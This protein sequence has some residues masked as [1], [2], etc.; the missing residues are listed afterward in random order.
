MRGTERTGEGI[1][2]WRLAAA[3]AL[4]A[5][6]AAPALAWGQL[7]LPVVDPTTPAARDTE[8]VILT[9][10][11]FGEW[12]VRPNVTVKLPLTDLI[13]CNELQHELEGGS[14]DD[15]THNEY[16]EPEVDT[17][18][19]PIPEGVPVDRLLGYRWD[20]SRWRQIPFQVDEA[21][22]RY[23][24]NSASGFALYS[25]QDRHTTYAFDREGF[26]YTESDP[27][28]PCLARPRGGVSTTADPVRGLD[29][30]DELTFMAS[31][32]GQP[33]PSGT[34]LPPGVES[35]RAV[36][37]VDPLTGDT[38]LAYVMLA[39]ADGPRPAFGA[40]DG[41]VRY[42]RD[43]VS[44]L[45]EFS[46]SSYDDYGNAETG[47][48]CDAEGNV[49]GTGR[50]RPRDYATIETS[51]YRFRYDGRWLMTQIRVSPDGG[52]TYGPDLVDRW[53][54]RAFQQD[55]GSETPCCGYEEE[56][57]NWGGSSTLLGERSG[58]VRTIRETWGADSGT[59]VVRR[60][61]FYRDEVRQKNYLRVHVIP[62][63]DGIYAQWDFNAG[64]MTRFR[65]TRK[66]E[67][68]PVDGRND[69]VFGNFDDPCNANYDAN[70]TGDVDQGYRDLYAQLG[71][72]QL[73]YHQSIDVSDPT[74]GEANAALG[75]SQT[76]GPSGTIVD[77]IQIDRVT[78]LSPGGAAQAMAAVPYYRDDSCFDD[79]T[80]TDPGPRLK[81]R[82]PDE[83]R[84]LPDG[85]AR[86]CWRPEDG[87]PEGS[88]RFFQGSIATHGL[89]LL[90]LVDSDNA[91]L[92]YPV[93]EIVAEQ[94]M[95]ML[96]GD[97]GNVGERYGRGFEKPLV[98]TV[99]PA[100]SG[101]VRLGPP[102]GDDSPVPP[103]I[104]PPGG[105]DD[106]GGGGP[107]S[108]TPPSETPP[109]DRPP[110]G[111]PSPGPP[112]GG[113]P[114]G[115][116]SGRPRSSPAGGGS[117]PAARP[118]VARRTRVR[119]GALRVPCRVRAARRCAIAVLAGRRTIGRGAASA[120]PGRRVTV[121]VRLT[122]AGRRL[123]ARS[124]RGL[125]V[126]ILARPIPGRARTIRSTTLVG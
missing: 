30:D 68:V 20:G 35:A 116:P 50:R 67:G 39:A 100:E 16:A 101:Q 32:A 36:P 90:F 7:P 93:N 83:P 8:P 6:L 60:E 104:D 89:H 87:A 49:I 71:A 122:R 114:G 126:R 91:R 65:N 58:P 22:T 86:R 70:D 52:E 34:P 66:P 118:T 84:T 29:D 56:D 19:G 12:S 97:P 42:R 1:A 18:D 72:C 123:L 102:G 61:T 26:R 115:P 82:S 88:D 17:A 121:T 105:G 5:A 98:T 15:C 54:A 108:G 37:V 120:R 59:N 73:P 40:G 76:S 14:R 103:G 4:L 3:T 13:G 43:A 45:F 119:A 31:D 53:K 21:F 48:Y 38:K 106:G 27:D 62:P 69:E 112:A 10:S 109:S 94:R 44:E 96:P 41:Y 95:V 28:D 78:E 25:G 113:P 117:S 75:W 11:A 99:G 111:S 79:G 92:T 80:G 107:G 46:E 63:L 2:R 51:R 74:F 81:L 9:G 64:V 124:R 57:T 33:A 23:L 77:R 55:P 110:Y 24:D 47:P 125:R 85:T